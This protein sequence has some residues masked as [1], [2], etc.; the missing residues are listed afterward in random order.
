[1]ES[2]KELVDRH[3]RRRLEESFGKAMA[4][5]IM[6]SATTAAHTPV[7]GF[8]REDYKRLVEAV[9]CDQR[10]VDMWGAA[11]AA[12]ARREWMLLTP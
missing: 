4:M 1:M 5:M 9:C 11:G 6:A 12:D 2:Y 8:A 7:M 10:V 3:V